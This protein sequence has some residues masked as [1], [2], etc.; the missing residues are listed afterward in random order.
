MTLQEILALSDFAAIKKELTTKVKPKVAN[1][2]LLKQID[3]LLH[4]VFDEAKRPKKMVNKA[5]GQ[6]NE[7]GEPI[8]TTAQEEVA[9]IAFSFQ[10]VITE[11]GIGFLLGNPI[12]LFPQDGD[13][14]EQQKKLIAM[15]KKIWNKTKMDYRNQDVATKMFSECEVAELWYLVDAEEGYWGDLSKGKFK[16]KMKILAESLGDLL[17]PYFDGTGD[18]VAFSREYAITNSG[19]VESHFD[20]YT[21]D[22][23]IKY[24]TIGSAQTVEIKTNAVKKIPIIYYKQNEP[25]WYK[26]QPLIERLET[27]VSNR[28]DSNDYSGAPITVVT[29]ELQ[30]FAS[31]GEQGKVLQVSKDGK[32]EYLESTNAVDSVKLEWDVLKD[33]IYALTQTPDISFTQMKGLGA[34]SGIALKLMFLDAHMKAR[35]K[36]ATFGEG[37][38]RRIN[39][40]IAMIANV[41]ETSLAQA[42]IKLDLV[43]VF[44]PYLPVNE[45]EEVD[46]ISVAKTA[47]VMSTETGVRR[48][49]L[50][51]NVDAELLLIKKDAIESIVGSA[52]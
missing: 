15:V 45:K 36:E 49:P 46:I 1:A 42:A 10:Q 48:N 29:G 8:Y 26:V 6:K 39:L 43:P 44:T 9:R 47:G 38:Q 3:P 23:T 31:K 28:S 41:I 33:S 37:V 35:K 32:I 4:N 14:S 50:V 24:T 27:A 11:R 13:D 34:V 20:I 5:S 16:P 30:G 25:D 22:Q 12:E 2:D 21:A 52:V 18:M 19:V 7:A 40:L 51:S 17:Y